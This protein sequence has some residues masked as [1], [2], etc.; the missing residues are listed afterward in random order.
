M[1]LSSQRGY[2]D[3]GK[4]RPPRLLA[5]EDNPNQSDRELLPPPFGPARII[6][7]EG[8]T[9]R[10]NGPKIASRR[11]IKSFAAQHDGARIIRELVRGNDIDSTDKTALRGLLTTLAC[12]WDHKHFPF[13]LGEPSY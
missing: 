5:V 7:S 9:G 3:S 2:S 1:S 8:F 11:T 13:A 12:I 4:S 10:R 6:S